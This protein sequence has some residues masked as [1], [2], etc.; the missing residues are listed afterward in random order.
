MWIGSLIIVVLLPVL[1]MV[2]ALLLNRVPLL[3]APG[4]GTRLRTYLGR[5]VAE[6][7]PDSIF[8]EL[9]PQ[10]Y[11]VTS[12]HLCEEIPQ[13]LDRLGWPW[14]A[15]GDCRYS[16]IVT[17][18]LF[19]FKDDLT[20]GVTAVGSGS[21]HLKVRSQSR[22]STGDFGANTRHILALTRAIE[23]QLGPAN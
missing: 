2:A 8:P 9:R 10:T 21:S 3:T 18:P 12:A 6:L 23:A 16:A 20:I 11:P 14:Q 7:R 17:T 22:L 15:D 1:L 13:A 4:I 19:R 5:N